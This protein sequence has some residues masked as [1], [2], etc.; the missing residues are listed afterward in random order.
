CSEPRPEDYDV[1]KREETR[2]TFRVTELG[3]SPDTNFMWFN[4]NPERSQTSGKPLVSPHKLKWF[5]NLD[6]RRAVAHSIDRS[7]IIR[8]VYFGRGSP[9][10][11]PATKA[12]RLW[13]HPSVRKYEYDLRTARRLLESAGFLDADGDGI[14]EDS[15]GNEVRFTL[16]TNSESELR[17]SM[18][19]IIAQDL[20]DIGMRVDVVPMDFSSLVTRV[21][22]SKNYEACLL[23]L[24]RG[25]PLDPAMGLNVWKSSGRTHFWYP[26]QASPATPWEAEI[27][28]LMELQLS[29]PDYSR[30]KATYDRVQEIVCENAAL[31]YTA[32]P[33]LFVAVNSRLGNVRPTVLRERVI[34]NIQ[35]LY[36]KD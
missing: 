10:W 20:K 32:S 2:G 14:L 19:N 7:A 15:G 18:A 34:W 3:P 29:V 31:I 33:D 36:W 5:Q 25:V 9:V 35:C 21:R 1:L 24:S 26:E 28:S 13:H 23:G 12:D 16:L 4:M 22:E 6:F 11:A 8:A 27:D 30:R 17:V